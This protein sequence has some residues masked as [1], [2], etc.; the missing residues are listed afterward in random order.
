MH[1]SWHGSMAL[2]PPC[3]RC[4]TFASIYIRIDIYSRTCSSRKKVLAPHAQTECHR[5]MT[6]LMLNHTPINQAERHAAGGVQRHRGV[7][8]A[9]TCTVAIMPQCLHGAQSCMAI[10]SSHGGSLNSCM[11]VGRL[12]AFAF[13]AVEDYLSART[14]AARWGNCICTSTR[15]HGYQHATAVI[16]HTDTCR[17]AL[18]CP[19]QLSPALPRPLA[20]PAP[21]RPACPLH[22]LHLFPL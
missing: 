2:R 21:P 5:N 10:V 6:V 18:P 14:R 19:A 9:R 1:G 22:P 4:S 17:P 20:R 8:N 13:I 3:G 11:A 15:M 7:T 12:I 16:M